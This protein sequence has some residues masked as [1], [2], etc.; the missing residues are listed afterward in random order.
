M[1]RLLVA[2]LLALVGAQPSAAQAPAAAPAVAGPRLTIDGVVPDADRGTLTISGANF[3]PRPFVTLDLVPL[4]IQLAIDARIVAVAPLS[5]MPPGTYLLTVARGAQ[6]GDAASFEVRLGPEPPSPAAAT[7]ATNST[8]APAGVPD[9]DAHVPGATEAAARVGDTVITVADVDREWQRTDPAGYLRAVRQL[10]DGRRRA[11]TELVN[12]ELLAREAA[13]RG[14]SVEALLAEELRQRT[15]PLPDT[16]V[17]ALY[18]SLGDRTRGASLDQMRPALRAWFAR[19]TEPEL[20]RMT[21][22]EE[23]VKVSTRADTLLPAPRV[24]VSRNDDDPTLGSAMAA[25][26]I[27]MFGDF[28]DPL[29]ARYALMVPRVRELF[30]SRVLFVFKHLPSPDP[31]SVESAE[32]AACANAQERFWEF[33][34]TLLGRA[35]ALDR[36]RYRAVAAEVKLDVAK[37]D[38]CLDGGAMRARVRAAVDEARRYGITSSGSMLVNGRLAPEPPSFLPPLEFFRRLVEEELQ[39]QS[40]A[41]PR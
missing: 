33:H 40:T 34:D 25:V 29:Y 11:A 15:V 26:E 17:T 39:R 14:V 16:A 10:Y 35:G 1:T 12:R 28:A 21:Y 18:Q 8:S 6:T 27:V 36:A 9:I 20:A 3:G 13:S 30:G 5:M 23:L 22:L 7:T 37:L 4:N 32:A 41:P 24:T 19:K 38:A 31:A 2:A